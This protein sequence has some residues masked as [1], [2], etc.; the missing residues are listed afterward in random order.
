MFMILKPGVSYQTYFERRLPHVRSVHLD[1][2]Y[3][4]NFGNLEKKLLDTQMYNFRT[5]M[6]DPC[7]LEH[8]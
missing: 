4:K 7:L 3:Y 1:K 5:T 8:N 6:C 2:N